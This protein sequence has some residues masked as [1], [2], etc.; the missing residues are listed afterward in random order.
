MANII[1][2]EQ[3]ARPKKKNIAPSYLVDFGQRTSSWRW[4]WQAC[5]AASLGLTAFSSFSVLAKPYTDTKKRFAL[6]MPTGWQLAPMPGDTAGMMFRREIDGVPGI[7]RVSVRS[8]VTGE[9]VRD[10]LDRFEAPFRAEI[11]Y[12][13]GADIPTSIGLFPG[14]R[15]NFTVFAN[16]DSRTVRS[17][18]VHIVQAFGSVHQIHFETLE[19]SRSI[20]ARDVE[21]FLASYE[22]LIGQGIYAPLVG[23][24]RGENTPDLILSEDGRF[25]LDK[26]NGTFAADGGV[27]VLRLPDGQE[28][29]RYKVD[30]NV[31][32]LSSNN[33]GIKT[34]KR[35]GKALYSVP[36]KETATPAGAPKR[37]ELLGRWRVMNVASTEVYVLHLAPS[38]AVSFGP[39]SGQ[40]RYERGLLT[41]TSTAG[42]TVTYHVSM[43]KGRLRMGG[44]DLDKELELMRE[45]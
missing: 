27:M 28:S 24:W 12:Q 5:L 23:T 31:L 32:I 22:P 11:G 26:I 4:F 13:A 38:G 2:K 3:Q 41:I 39:L 40:F 20:F 15:R 36:S 42:E 37:E 8:V 29:Y 21:K 18:E 34:Y 7:L 1:E 17:V 19:S 35:S 45:P 10:A 33:L 14:M 9:N 25:I 30:G 6:D 43:Q 44:G 16:G